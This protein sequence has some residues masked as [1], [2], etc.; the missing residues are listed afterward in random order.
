MLVLF[1]CFDMIPVPWRWNTME[2]LISPL[3]IKK[4]YLN[5]L[6][7]YKVLVR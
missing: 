1:K 7:N 5:A 3:I 6:K 4:K 2:K